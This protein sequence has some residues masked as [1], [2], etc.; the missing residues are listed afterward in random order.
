MQRLSG[1]GL[2]FH[3][4]RHQT[5][6]SLRRWWPHTSRVAAAHVSRAHQPC[7]RTS[8]GSRGG[9]CPCALS[10]LCTK[11]HGAKRRQGVVGNFARPHQVPECSEKF[12][13][14]GAAHTGTELAPKTRTALCKC[15]TNLIVHT[16]LRSIERFEGR[17]ERAELIGKEQ[18]DSSVIAAERTRTNPHHFAT[19]AQVVQHRGPITTYS[20]R[21]NVGFQGGCHECRSRQRGKC[22]RQRVHTVHRCRHTVPFRHET[23][24]RVLI[25]WF[26]LFA[27]LGKRPSTHQA[28][29]FGITPLALGSERAKLATHHPLRSFKLRKHHRNAIYGHTET[30][31]YVASNER[32]MGSCIPRNEFEQWRVDWFGECLR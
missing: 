18:A 29:H 1:G 3:Q 6:A 11:Q 19:G 12:G 8:G 28:Q 30:L 23:G 15:G 13:I 27:Q 25:D 5:P 2:L 32:R 9:K 4:L 14:R 20:Q 17:K 16:T 7:R 10:A 26:D 24:E 31:C 22:F 21:Q